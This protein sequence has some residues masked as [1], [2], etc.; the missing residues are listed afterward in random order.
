MN[1]KLALEERICEKCNNKEIEDEPH[2][3][4]KCSANAD[5]RSELIRIATSVVPDFH[6]LTQVDQFKMIMTN[7]DPELI[8][9][10]GNFLN[11]IL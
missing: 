3:L 11:D 8:K 5:K 10:L 1:P 2:C 9:V 7:K 4:L 6:N